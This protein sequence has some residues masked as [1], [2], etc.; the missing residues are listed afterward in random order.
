MH[1][2]LHSPLT[3]TM[4]SLF[5]LALLTTVLGGCASSKPSFYHEENFSETDTYSRTFKESDAATCEAARRA[6]LSQGY[7]ISKASNNIVDGAKSFQPEAD[8]HMEIAF[9]IVCAANGK[10]DR[11]TAVFVSATQDR[12]ALKKTNNSASLGVSIIGSVSMPFSSSDDSLVRVASETISSAIFYDRFFGALERYLA[13]GAE[14][15]DPTDQHQ[16]DGP[17]P[18]QIKKDVK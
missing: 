5:S 12:Y 13:P 6:L 1:R 18:S 9:H 15:T 4:N 16:L 14:I 3:V 10:A 2:L 11:N 7:I 8:Q 17:L